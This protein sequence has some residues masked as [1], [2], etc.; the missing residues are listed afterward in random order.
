MTRRKGDRKRAPVQALVDVEGPSLPV[1]APLPQE[2]A[3]SAASDS[4]TASYD[5]RFHEARVAERAGETDKAIALYREL[6]RE[7]PNDI[8]A[9]NNLGCLFEKRGDYL[10][11]LEQYEAA[12]AI[13]PDNVSI[14]L[15]IGGVLTMLS[16]FD[17]AERELRHAQKL[18]PSRPDVYTQLGI[19]YFKRGRYPLA[20]VE[21]KRAIELD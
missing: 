18:D 15:N 16:K 4:A 17:Q 20:D 6:L 12:R 3:P 13:A 2:A 1:E 8:R 14:L 5:G 19:M 11:A 9:R 10:Q 7:A 21:L